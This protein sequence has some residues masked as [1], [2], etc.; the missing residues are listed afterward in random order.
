MAAVVGSD[1][2]SPTVDELR[3]EIR[4]AVGRHERIE[5]TGFTKEELQAIAVALGYLSESS[6]RP[7]K[8][9]MRA[10]IRWRI[11]RR[12]DDDPDGGERAFTKDEL[13][14]VASAIEERA[15][16]APGTGAP[17]GE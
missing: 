11:G 12:D 8:S 7:P 9:Q 15:E 13:L 17:G 1:G 5:T 6:A 10:G 4:A 3:N 2:M 14:D 16:G